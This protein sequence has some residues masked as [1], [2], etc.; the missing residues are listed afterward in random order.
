MRF[1]RKHKKFEK[2]VVLSCQ[3]NYFKKGDTIEIFG[4]GHNIITYKI[5]KILD[6]DDNEIEVV[7][8]PR[9]IVKMQIKDTL[10]KDDMLRIKFN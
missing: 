5:D 1:F 6:E 8:H 10:Y 3:R 2:F 9:Q 7:R 4:S